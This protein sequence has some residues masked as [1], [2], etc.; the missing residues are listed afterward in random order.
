MD[1]NRGL[2]IASICKK[3]LSGISRIHF[4][5]SL[6]LEDNT[7]YWIDTDFVNRGKY[8]SAIQTVIS[9]ETWA[10]GLKSEIGSAVDIQ[11]GIRG[12]APQGEALCET[13]LPSQI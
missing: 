13:T 4:T 1:T 12:P 7:V 2:L 5:E 3:A 9:T 6:L 8:I 10:D 11:T